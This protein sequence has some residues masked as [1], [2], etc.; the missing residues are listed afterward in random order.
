MESLWTPLNRASSEIRLLEIVPSASLTAAVTVKLR[1][2]RLEDAR[3]EGFIPLSYVWGD[4]LA[5]ETILVN[6]VGVP[7]GRSLATFLRYVRDGPLH[8]LP[9]L[10]GYHGKVQFWADALCINQ[11]DVSERNHQVSL[12]RDI[13]ESASVGI[14]W[15]GIHEDA[16]KAKI[17]LSTLAREWGA[18]LMLTNPL[19]RLAECGPDFGDWMSRFPHFFEENRTEGMKNEYWNVVHRV[20]EAPYWTRV[21]TYQE[22]VLP[23]DTCFMSGVVTFSREEIYTVCEWIA[24]FRKNS[25]NRTFDPSQGA[26]F[27]L[28][29]GSISHDWQFRLCDYLQHGR[30]SSLQLDLILVLVSTDLNASDPRDHI[31]GLLGVVPTRMYADYALTT[32]EV[33][34]WFCR[35]WIE[36]KGSLQFLD[37]AGLS[38]H[39]ENKGFDLPSW[40]VDWE[41]FNF[42]N[43]RRKHFKQ[44]KS[45][46]LCE[47]VIWSHSSWFTQ[48]YHSLVVTGLCLDEVKHVSHECRGERSASTSGIVIEV[49]SI[50]GFLYQ[51]AANYVSIHGTSVLVDGTHI[52]QAL[53]RLAFRTY[54]DHSTRQGLDLMSVQTHYLALSFLHALVTVPFE[55]ET[56]D[57]EVVARGFRTLGLDHGSG[58]GRQYRE[59][60]FPQAREAPYLQCWTDYTSAQFSPASSSIQLDFSAGREMISSLDRNVLFHTKSG[61]LGVAPTARAGDEIASI[62]GY[63][64]LL[65]LRKQSTYYRLVGR[66][67][68]S[69][70]TCAW[71]DYYSAKEIEIR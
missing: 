29:Y 58:F 57:A 39:R 21:W 42:N 17:L 30:G 19:D 25:S 22:M 1:T 41:Y 69:N 24:A 64:D 53:F 15:L 37:D 20:F 8:R 62:N 70:T 5:A 61:H 60:V 45:V 44:D 36:E 32:K 3:G 27:Q 63:H 16:D 7:I 31:Y 54:L 46:A 34:M 2:R 35:T 38:S 28:Q 52:I 4:Q 33:Y 51:W 23:K 12:M 68:V 14:C 49:A 13:Y 6:E 59:E 71:S 10:W 65:L 26:I 18:K 67:A 48:P 47:G 55:I 56:D 40:A 11:G 50:F 66:C 9:G 43:D